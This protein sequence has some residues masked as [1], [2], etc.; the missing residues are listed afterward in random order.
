MSCTV[1]CFPHCNVL[2][3][4]KS[5]FRLGLKLSKR[6]AYP[7]VLPNSR[8]RGIIRRKIEIFPTKTMKFWI[9]H[10]LVLRSNK[11]PTKEKSTAGLY[12]LHFDVNEYAKEINKDSDFSSRTI[13]LHLKIHSTIQI[14]HCTFWTDS[15]GPWLDLFQQTRWQKKDVYRL[16]RKSQ[17]WCNM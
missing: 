15:R 4:H 12:F 3:F 8:I 2:C 17:H 13:I 16:H 5:L 9:P 6:S 11:K 14:R 7:E 1:H 10:G